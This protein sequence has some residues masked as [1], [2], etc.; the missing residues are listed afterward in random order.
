MIMRICDGLKK[1]KDMLFC[2]FEVK[3]VFKNYFII[4]SKMCDQLR[5]MMWFC[6]M[7]DVQKGKFRF[8]ICKNCFV[9]IFG[10]FLFL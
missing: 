7:I 3:L 5:E 4:V 1:I 10:V 9:G 2:C 8:K 6:F